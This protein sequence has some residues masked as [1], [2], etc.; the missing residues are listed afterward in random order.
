MSLATSPC[1]KAKGHQ[2]KT[3]EDNC[4]LKNR[5][6]S[7]EQSFVDQSGYKRQGFV[8][9]D[10]LKIHYKL[11]RPHSQIKGTLI[12]EKKLDFLDLLTTTRSFSHSSFRQISGIFIFNF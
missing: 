4:L 10:Q 5:A 2:V 12:L 1:K 9:A 7:Y 6:D 8:L 3:Y 11:Q